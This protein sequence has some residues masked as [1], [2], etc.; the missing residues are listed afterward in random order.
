MTNYPEKSKLDNTVD[1]FNVVAQIEPTGICSLILEVIKF[2]PKSFERR[3]EDWLKCIAEKIENMPQEQEEQLRNFFEEEEGKTLLFQATVAAIA[4]HKRD[5]L[6]AIRNVLLNTICDSN[7]Y[8]DQKEIYVGII[9]D[10]EPYDLVLLKIINTH[11]LEFGA[12]DS[13]EGAFAISKANGFDGDRDD[14]FLMLNKLRSKSLIRIS[15]HI[16]GF[17]DVYTVDVVI[18]GENESGYSKPKIKVTALAEKLIAY[19]EE[20]NS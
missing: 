11:C 18:I 13:Y 14:F 16:N 17:D 3:Q 8:Y 1:A 10:L 15:E 19:I 4:T 12:V 5:K 7:S 9:T 6:L 2:H 20:T